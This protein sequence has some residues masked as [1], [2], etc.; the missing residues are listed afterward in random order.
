M[1]W[2]QVFCVNFLLISLKIFIIAD[3]FIYFCKLIAMY[4]Q[5][6]NET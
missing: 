3:T 1:K 4:S 2:K 5:N 6:S